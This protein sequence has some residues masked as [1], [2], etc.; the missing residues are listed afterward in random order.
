MILTT[1]CNVYYDSQ[2]HQPSDL[3]YNM[4]CLQHPF[5]QSHYAAALPTP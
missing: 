2:F 1:K 4:A 3:V 5:V